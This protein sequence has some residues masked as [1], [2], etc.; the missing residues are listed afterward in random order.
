MK[1][2]SC[3]LA[4]LGAGPGGYVC[5]IRAG[6][7]GLDI[8]IVEAGRTRRNLPQRR[9]HSLQGADPRRRRIRKR[10]GDGERARGRSASPLAHARDR[11]RQDHRLEGRRS[12]AGSADGV[13]GLLKRG[14]VKIV[15]GTAQFRDGK[16]VEV[17]TETGSQII[18]AEAIVIATGSAPVALPTLPFGGPVISS[19]E[20][21]ALDRA[22]R[23]GSSS[24]AP[25]ISASNSATA[26]AKL[27]SAV[28]VVEAEDRAC[29]R[30]TTPN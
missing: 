11:S 15:A 17:E 10:D 20:A 23:R 18:R 29:C 24:S 25:A 5:A 26:F 27:G 21:L 4:V 30:Y 13:A 1:E 2:I 14:K 19:T 12:S 3:K 22:A 8:V 9:L 6:Q 28:T 7:L 16:T